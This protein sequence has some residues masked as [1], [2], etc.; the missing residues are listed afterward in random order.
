[1]SRSVQVWVKVCDYCCAI[2]VP[3]GLSW[4]WNP[5]EGMWP[6]L[7]AGMMGWNIRFIPHVKFLFF[8]PGYPQCL[9]PVGR[10]IST[11]VNSGHF[12]RM[13]VSSVGTSPSPWMCALSI[14]PSPALSQT[15][16]TVGFI[17]LFSSIPSY[18]AT[19]LLGDRWPSLSSSLSTP[20]EESE[21]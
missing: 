17:I 2:P 21:P 5:T 4:G 16:F 11:W 20:R 12:K 6:V 18:A 13:E 9:F 14:P 1:M 15:I 3:H 8:L 7:E 19:C 10:N